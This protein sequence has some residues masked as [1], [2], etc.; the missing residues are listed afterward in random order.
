MFLVGP[1]VETVPPGG[2]G[3]FF[4]S[5]SRVQ[6]RFLLKSDMCEAERIP[7]N[8]RLRL[9]G[10]CETA[11]LCLK[12]LVSVQWCQSASSGASLFQLEGRSG[13][14]RAHPSAP[15]GAHR[16]RKIAEG[17]EG[18][19]SPQRRHPCPHSFSFIRLLIKLGLTENRSFN[20][21]LIGS[22][23]RFRLAALHR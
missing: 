3:S 10:E 20:E 8:G 6:R 7:G 14:L 11:F 12:M 21:S 18:V 5:F 15:S 2:H 4:S 1:L 19:A 17:E 9:V 23:R 22:L 13:L 16:L